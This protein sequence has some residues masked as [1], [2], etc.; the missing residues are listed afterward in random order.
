MLKKYLGNIWPTAK[1]ARIN[2]IFLLGGIGALIAAVTYTSHKAALANQYVA[3]SLADNYMF[4]GVN[5]LDQLAVPGTHTYLLKWPVFL[6]NN[7]V[8]F[9]LQTYVAVSVGLALI[10]YLGFLFFVYKVAPSIR[11]VGMTALA[12]ALIVLMTK[13]YLTDESFSLMGLAMPNIRNIEYLIYFAVLRNH[14]RL[15]GCT[16]KAGGS[17]IFQIFQVSSFVV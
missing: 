4:F 9:N 12:L 17:T 3:D 5:G 15:C 8:G 6:L 16:M 13:T 10:T 7:A 14:Y 1:Q 11:I 2:R